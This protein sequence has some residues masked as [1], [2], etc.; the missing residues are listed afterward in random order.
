MREKDSNRTTLWVYDYLVENGYQNV[1]EE[2]AHVIIK[3]LRKG[4][5]PKVS[6]DPDQIAFT[7]VID[8]LI[9]HDYQVVA[10]ELQNEVKYEKVDLL[11]LDLQTILKDKFSKSKP[12]FSRLSNPEHDPSIWV[13][14]YLVKY[15]Y[16]NVADELVLALSDKPE[17]DTKRERRSQ[18]NCDKSETK[19]SKL[20][21]VPEKES[22]SKKRKLES[23]DR[24][25]PR[26]FKL[27]DSDQ[28]NEDLNEKD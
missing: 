20:R 7:L 13:H 9:K 24:T 23:C 5:K 4:S 12:K 27:S 17:K 21:Q 22:E 11:G 14:D 19:V 15:G 8:Y 1:A 18:S 25:Q 2:F 10:K 3:K 16:Q 28:S 26:V 6:A